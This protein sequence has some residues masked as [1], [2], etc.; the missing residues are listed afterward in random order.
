M[1]ESQNKGKMKRKT[2][3]KEKKENVQL[4]LVRILQEGLNCCESLGR[5]FGLSESEAG[6]NRRDNEQNPLREWS[7]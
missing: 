1:E 4:V 5:L 6:R 3:D 7:R 2:C